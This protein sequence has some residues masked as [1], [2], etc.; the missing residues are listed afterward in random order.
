M[1][2]SPL[3]L[4][5]I[6]PLLF[7]ILPQATPHPRPPGIADGQKQIDKPLEPPPEVR[8][9]RLNI[10]QVDA[11]T[12]ELQRLANALPPQ[13][14]QVTKGQIPKDLGENLKRIEKL[15]KHLRSEV[16]P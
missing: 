10:D 9:R 3:W 4:Y 16:S 1:R 14:D 8:N 7:Q 15:A 11:E 13:I 5:F 2:L 12:Q 6:F